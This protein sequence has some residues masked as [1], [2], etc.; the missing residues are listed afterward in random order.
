VLVRTQE[1]AGIP[2]RCFTSHWVAGMFI[3]QD[4]T[5]HQRIKSFSL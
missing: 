5:Q 1:M 3:F 2:P 4:G